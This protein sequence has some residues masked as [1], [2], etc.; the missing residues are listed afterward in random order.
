MYLFIENLLS[1][2]Q[3]R[4]SNALV[5]IFGQSYTIDKI[6]DTIF[7]TSFEFVEINN[8]GAK[9]VFELNYF[10]SA[11]SSF[12]EEIVLFENDQ[13]AREYVKLLVKNNF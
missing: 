5:V 11:I 9:T 13:L 8:I 3:K 2:L 6:L 7:Y 12:I 1:D 4:T 10:K